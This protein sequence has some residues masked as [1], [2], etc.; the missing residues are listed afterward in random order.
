ATDSAN[1]DELRQMAAQNDSVD[2]GIANAY[3]LKTGMSQ[4]DLFQLMSNQTFMDAKT[5]IDKG[6]ADEMA[7][8]SKTQTASDKAP[9][10]ANSIAKLPSRET[11]DKF[12]LLM[13]KAKAF[14]KISEAQI[15]QKKIQRKLHQK[16]IKKLIV[17]HR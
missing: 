12:N 1:A 15:L 8:T 16:K 11:I 3:M 4:S 9:V 7:F 14:D 10:F 2:I 17:S 5:A 13:G 6:F